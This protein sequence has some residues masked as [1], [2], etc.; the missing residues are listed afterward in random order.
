MFVFFNWGRGVLC[1]GKYNNGLGEGIKNINHFRDV[2]SSCDDDHF[3]TL[4]FVFSLIASIKTLRCL[5]T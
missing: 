2:T 4:K 1:I 5:Q 3:Q